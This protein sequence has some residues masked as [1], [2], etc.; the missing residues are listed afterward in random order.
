MSENSKATVQIQAPPDA[1]GTSSKAP[2]RRIPI[3]AT[4]ETN[5]PSQN[6]K[7]LLTLT[8][9]KNH[10][11]STV[12]QVKDVETKSTLMTL[13]SPKNKWRFIWDENRIKSEDN[14]E[15]IMTL[16]RKLMTICD[17]H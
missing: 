7:L 6:T 3:C 5:C 15:N 10:A 2:L 11:A 17:L 12:I 16:R 14:P 9:N 8:T 13:S 1:P 4:E